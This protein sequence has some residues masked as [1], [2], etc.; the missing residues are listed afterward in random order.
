MPRNKPPHLFL[1]LW[2]AAPSIHFEQTSK[3][4][5]ALLSRIAVPHAWLFRSADRQAQWRLET[6]SAANEPP[7]RGNR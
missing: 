7:Y 1:P 5:G 3:N 6:P 2:L 4:I